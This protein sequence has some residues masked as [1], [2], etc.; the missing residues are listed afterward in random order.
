MN[1]IDAKTLLEKRRIPY[2]MTQYEGETE[3][4]RHLTAFPRRDAG[5]KCPVTA[6][7]I[8]AVNGEKHIEM[9][10]NRARGGYVFEELYF[11]GF[12]FELCDCEPDML[13][14][15]LMDIIGRI[16]DGKLAVIECCDPKRR[17][18]I[19]SGSFDLKDN[20]NVFGAPGFREAIARIEKPRT[21]RQKL[22]GRKRQYDIYDWR[23]CRQILK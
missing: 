15:E 13:E 11:G 1:L 22:I 19:S 18:W 23:T 12:S 5:R 14:A 3:Y 8:P 6:L 2:H 17:R 16:V 9:Q 21:F 7:V 4:F 10:F 20:D